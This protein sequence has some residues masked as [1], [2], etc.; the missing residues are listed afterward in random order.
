M[1]YKPLLGTDLSGH[2]GGLVASHN[3]YGPYFRQRVR[4]VNRK[5]GAQRSQRAAVAATSQQWRGL[6]PTVRAAWT[7]AS[8]VKVSRKGDRV[9]LTGQA[10]YQFVNTIRT[11]A[12]LAAINAPPSSTTVPS[13]SYPTATF[14]SATQISLDVVLS[15][16]WSAT[17]GWMILSGSLSTSPG[18][19]FKPANLAI[20]IELGPA[21]STPIAIPLPFAV[22]IGGT[23]RLTAHA[24]SPDGRQSQYVDTL[25]TNP[26]FPA[27]PPALLRVLEVTHIGTKTYMWR[28]DGPITVIGSTDSHLILDG[29]TTA[30][31]IAQL[32]PTSLQA[33][34]SS[35]DGTTVPW[36]IDS[37]PNVGILQSVVVPQSGTTD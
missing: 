29:D 8:I 36:T 6:D 33:T 17:G 22:P 25:A 7:A 37:Q 20:A 32:G 11:R 18:V 26:S 15:D 1:K 3:T 35:A 14:T 19:A 12:G 2:V 21:A 28:F 34:Y 24:G 31:S 10:A 27:P 5:T 4:P 9:T 30:A 16:E 13:L 23:L